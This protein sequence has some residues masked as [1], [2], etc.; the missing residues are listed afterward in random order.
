MTCPL[1]YWETGKWIFRVE[2]DVPEPTIREL[3]R[4]QTENLDGFE[5]RDT[6]ASGMVIGE[7]RIEVTDG[8]DP[9]EVAKELVEIVLT[10]HEDA[11]QTFEEYP[12]FGT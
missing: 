1:G 11:V 8:G 10:V 9:A 4:E 3:F 12:E 2:I 7:K 6:H 5:L